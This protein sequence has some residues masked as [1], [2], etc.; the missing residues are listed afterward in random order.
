VKAI[1]TVRRGLPDKHNAAPPS[2]Y[3]EVGDIQDTVTCRFQLG[4]WSY[5]KWGWSAGAGDGGEWLKG[6]I[7]RLEKG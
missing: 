5:M 4:Q 6:I 7:M 2:R 3:N 1:A